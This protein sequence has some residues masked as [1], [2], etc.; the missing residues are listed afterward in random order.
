MFEIPVEIFD[1][2]I[3]QTYEVEAKICSSS[4]TQRQSHHFCGSLSVASMDS[5]GR[6]WFGA[7][8]PVGWFLGIQGNSPKKLMVKK[9]K[10]L[11]FL[12]VSSKFPIHPNLLKYAFPILPLWYGYLLDKGWDGFPHG[13]PGSEKNPGDWD[14]V[15]SSASSASRDVL[16]IEWP[17]HP[18]LWVRCPL[19]THT[20][21]TLHFRLYIF[22]VVYF[23]ISCCAYSVHI[24][25]IYIYIHIITYIYWIFIGIMQWLLVDL[26]YEYPKFPSNLSHAEALTNFLLGGWTKRCHCEAMHHCR[27]IMLCRQYCI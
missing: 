26:K 21:W 9:I 22:S 13:F 5:G 7:A 19:F 1:Q 10:K 11:G 12:H 4:G 17:R 16:Y 24:Y 20:H 8:V 6:I 15:P 23:Y 14:P 27:M 2:W 25:S 3:D 18:N